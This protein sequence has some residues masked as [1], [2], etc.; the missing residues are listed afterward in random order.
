MTTPTI[1][2]MLEKVRDCDVRAKSHITVGNVWTEAAFKAG[3]KAACDVLIPALEEAVNTL[4]K[5]QFQTVFTREA[6]EHISYSKSG[7]EKIRSL[8]EG[9]AK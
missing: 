3:H 2:E 5:V 9:G 4:K 6:H 7:L 8:L 1:A